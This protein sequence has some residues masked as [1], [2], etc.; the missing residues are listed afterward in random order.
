MIEYLQN[1]FLPEKFILTKLDEYWKE[2]FPDW[3]ITTNS[4]IDR[5]IIITALIQSVEKL[6]FVGEQ[7]IP[8]CFG[9]ECIVDIKI[10]DGE[11]VDKNSIIGTIK[12]PAYIILEKERVMLNLIQRLSGIAS[13]TQEYV[14]IVKNHNIKILDTRKTT[15]G[16][17]LF[18]KYAVSIGGGFNHRLDLSK[19]IL[20]KDNHILSLGSITKAIES[21]KKNNPSLPIEL[22]VDT[23]KQ[24]KEALK[25]SING[26]LLDNMNPKKVKKA[27]EIIRADKA[28]KKIFIEV[29]GGITK[30]NLYSYV[31]TGINAI[32][33]GAITHSAISKDIKL[34]FI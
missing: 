2:D 13:Q 4:I 17:R 34:E 31:N 27:V 3:D 26:F 14:Q 5:D 21:I 30:N 25:M 23:L 20:I 15:P 16:L 22:E 33:V 6:V 24:I 28:G 19:G 7:I 1:N 29:S 8:H 9:K 32:S 18:E 11:F 12:G 10:K